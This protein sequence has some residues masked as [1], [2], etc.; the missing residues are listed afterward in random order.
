[1]IIDY[2]STL[3]NIEEECDKFKRAI[4]NVFFKGGKTKYYD[5]ENNITQ[6]R[7]YRTHFSNIRSC[8]ELSKFLDF[9][10]TGFDFQFFQCFSCLD[11]SSDINNIEDFDLYVDGIKLGFFKLHDQIENFYNS[12]D[13]EE[14]KRIN[15]SIHCIFECCF[16]SSVSMSVSAVES[17]LLKLM[18][19]VSPE[20][21][22]KLEKM[23]LGQLV[24]EYS[25]N[26]E[27]YKNIVPEKHTP[28]LDLLNT[29]RIFSVH[30]KQQEIT[31][32]IA[33]S[34]LNLSIEFLVDENTE[35]RSA[36]S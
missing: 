6:N 27:K 7:L 33:K 21:K 34:I 25:R 29:Y 23:A 5:K 24:F 16:F 17:R 14:R 31:S 12:F 20:F 1:M 30:P 28:L 8:V 9:K 11:S 4:V 2:F 10:V 18:C 3:K 35:I 26:K 22:N 13:E 19:N 15:E 36:Q 32:L